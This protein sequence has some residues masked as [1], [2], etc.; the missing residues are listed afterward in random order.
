MDIFVKKMTACHIIG[1]ENIKEGILYMVTNAKPDKPEMKQRLHG[2]LISPPALAK[3]AFLRY[4]TTLMFKATFETSQ[5]STGLSLFAMVEKDGDMRVIRL[6]PIA[7]SLFASVDEFNR[8]GNSD[9]E[10]YLG[11]MQEGFFTS[12]KFGKGTKV[13]C[14][15]TILASINPPVGAKALPN[16]KIDLN[17]M[18][19]IPAVMDRF[20]FRWYIM[21]MNEDDFDNLIDKKM[22]FVDRS[23]PDYSIFISKWIRYAKQRYNPNL[24]DIAREILKLAVKDLRKQNKELSPRVIET[25]ANTAKARA[26]FLLKDTVDESDAKAVIEFYN[27]MIQGYSAS[28]VEARNIVDIGVEICYDILTEIIA[29]V[30]IAYRFDDLLKEACNRNKHL[31]KYIKFG[32]AED[33]YFDRSENKRARNI[34]ERLIENYKSDIEF[35]CLKPVTLQVSIEKAKNKAKSYLTEISERSDSKQGDLSTKMPL[36]DQLTYLTNISGV[37]VN[38]KSENENSDLSTKKVENELGLPS[39]GRSDRSDS[40]IDEKS[41]KTESER[42]QFESNNLSDRTL[43]ESDIVYK[44]IRDRRNK[45]YFTVSA[46]N[47]KESN[48]KYNCPNSNCDYSDANPSKITKHVE[49]IH[50]NGGLD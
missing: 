46:K 12:N 26:R 16:G 31:A 30:T 36:S 41:T 24:S 47:T 14:P 43:E 49:D 13:V 10:K 15:V 17:A 42:Y 27:K 4:A 25:L 44:R 40:Q 7:R 19:I 5:T 21:P 32:I 50:G 29:D 9:Q 48:H 23:A 33:K 39:E 38:E 35:P 34:Y 22:E 2:I 37:G 18:N 28:Y 6:G 11:A 45:K 3:T 8:T 20:D 1:H